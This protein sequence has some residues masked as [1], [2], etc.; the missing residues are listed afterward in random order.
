MSDPA[1]KFTDGIHEA[2][3]AAAEATENAAESVA[4]QGAGVGDTL[5]AAAN[6]SGKAIKHAYSEVA[7][8]ARDSYE[9]SRDKV[10][11]WEAAL[12]DQVRARPLATLLVAI[13]VGLVGGFLLRGPIDHSRR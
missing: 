9:Y 13:G 6:Q 10:V 4:E 11:G 7:D 12:E 3:D 2:A 5:R 8:K 1:K